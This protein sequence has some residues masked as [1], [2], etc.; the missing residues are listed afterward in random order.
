[1]KAARVI[2]T[3][4]Y[5]DAQRWALRLRQ[6]GIDAEAFPLIEIAPLAHAT[7]PQALRDY[8]AC[9]F[10]SAHAVEHF[11]QENA[12]ITQQ[13]R[14]QAAINTIA[15][16]NAGPI[17]PE[18]RF[19][20]PGP[21]TVAALRAAGIAATHIDAPPPDAVQFDSAALWQVIGRRDW[22]GRRVLI[23]RGQSV[24]A[25]GNSPGRDWIAS[26]WREAGASVDFATVYQRRAP[27]L[28]EAQ[29][30]RARAAAADGSVWLFSSS[31]AVANLHCHAALQDL[32]WSRARALATHPRIAQA[33]RAAGWGVVEESRPSLGDI[34]EALR[35]IELRHP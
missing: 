14:A 34:G 5:R 25:E 15:N 32:D 4:P 35:S 12:D 24:G 26:Q 33:A 8:A 31:E 17:P 10:V 7:S 16:Q 3:R 21:G 23:V 30:E 6:A 9:L 19:M 1:M 28:D 29:L 11:F 13:P 20:A 18:L 22:Q 2:V 27:P